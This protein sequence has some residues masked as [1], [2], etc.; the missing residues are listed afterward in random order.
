QCRGPRPQRPLSV[1][2]AAAQSVLLAGGSGLVG[3]ALSALLRQLTP[4]PTVHQLVRRE[5]ADADASVRSTVWHTVDFS[6]LPT[7]P[8]AEWAFCCLGTTIR[9]AGSQQAFAAVDR[10]AVLAFAKAAHVAGVSRFA[11]VSALGANQASATFYNRIKGEMEAA[12]CQLGFDV[13]VI[14]RPSLLVGDRA[15]L[16]QPPRLA[17]RLALCATAPIAALLPARWRPVKALAVAHEMLAAMRR[18][19]PGVHIVESAD[20]HRPR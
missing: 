10:D 5:P 13:L 2:H 11:V 3:T 1:A 7:L 6:S 14:V 15:A 18:G 12:V 9:H 17:E 19:N 16:K 8:R 20:L 4:A